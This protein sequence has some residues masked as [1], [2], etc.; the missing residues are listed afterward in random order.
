M[1]FFKDLVKKNG[2][3]IVRYDE[4]REG[5]TYVK[6]FDYSVKYGGTYDSHRYYNNYV[7]DVTETKEAE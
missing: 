6:V 5:H 4:A 3:E 7:V 2:H 1:M